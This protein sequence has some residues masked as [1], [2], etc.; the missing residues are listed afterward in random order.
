MKSWIEQYLKEQTRAAAALPVSEIEA[1]VDLLRSARESGNQIFSCG[2]GGSAANCS[3]FAVDL[4]K[5]ASGSVA[6]TSNA[7]RPTSNIE[8]FR[9]LSLNDNV[10]WIT[11][12]SND[13]KY[14]DIFVEQLKNYGQSGDI[15]IGVSVSGN[16]P[17]VVK[18]VEWA[19]G[20]GMT[21]LGLVGNRKGNRL[22]R[23]A[24]RVIAVDSDHYGRVED[25]Q[26]HVLHLLCYAFIVGQA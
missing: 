25:W 9:V 7:Q 8:R 5:G 1:W 18:A 6:G 15:L 20:A 4:G 21:T 11:A 14:E 12:L 10:P 3:H 19:N 26:M 13:L 17:N 2:N 23:L 24:K 22:S 16:S